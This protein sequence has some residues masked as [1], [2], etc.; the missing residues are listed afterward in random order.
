MKTSKWLAPLAMTCALS[1]AVFGAASA[2]AATCTSAQ[3]GSFT[4]GSFT[5][6][7]DMWG[8]GANTQTICAN[9]AS[10]WWITSN[11]PNT[12]GIKAYGNASFYVGKPLSNITTLSSTLSETTPSG[13]A[14]DAAYDIWDSANSVEVMI[15]MNYTGTSSGGGN[16]KPASFNWSST[17]NA[18]PVYTN[19]NIGGVT[20]N[21]FEG[22][23]GHP[24]IS[25][26]RTTKT[27]NTTTDLKAVLNW[28]KGI[29]YFG[30]ITVGQVQYGVEVTST[31]STSKTWTMNNYTVTSR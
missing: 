29:G 8:S 1:G 28:I 2:D 23:V 27:N 14:W 9:S 4:I 12:N 31:D 5:F 25:L 10:N 20:Y 19:V 13:G 18:V 24:V 7:N 15:W 26:L 6:Y 17:G 11:Q 30:N 22:N 3:W 16:V 21:V